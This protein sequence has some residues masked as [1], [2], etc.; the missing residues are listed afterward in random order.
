MSRQAIT[1][2]Y[3]TAITSRPQTRE[4]L[5]EITNSN[6]MVERFNQVYG[7]WFPFG[8]S[9]A[10]GKGKV[11]WGWA[12]TWPHSPGMSTQRVDNFIKLVQKMKYPSPGKIANNSEQVIGQSRGRGFSTIL[13]HSLDVPALRK[14]EEYLNI[15]NMLFQELLEK[16][17][18][19]NAEIYGPDKFPDISKIKD[20]AGPGMRAKGFMPFVLKMAEDTLKAKFKM[21]TI[22]LKRSDRAR[23]DA[24]DARFVLNS[25]LT[26]FIFLYFA[27]IQNIMPIKDILRYGSVLDLLQAMNSAQSNRSKTSTKG[28]N[29]KEEIPGKVFESDDLLIVEPPSWQFSH[30]YF[31]EV[32]RS[33]YTPGKIIRGANW[34][35]SSSDQS[36]FDRYTNVNQNHLYYFLRRTKEEEI[37]ALRTC[38]AVRNFTSDMF[39][40]AQTDPFDIITAGIT[41]YEKLRDEYTHT[42]YNSRLQASPDSNRLYEMLMDGYIAAKFRYDDESIDVGEENNR[43]ALKLF[44]EAFKA[45]KLAKE[46]TPK[47][48]CNLF[49]FE[50][51]NQANG[52]MPYDSF[53]SYFFGEGDYRFF[54]Q[55][56]KFCSIFD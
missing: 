25:S 40:I 12:W 55:H 36:H 31:G 50:L 7:P 35:T 9:P 45:I 32:R 34:C 15:Y 44:Y 2:I 22:E 17:Y 16:A 26:N 49:T 27:K 6:K 3:E 41:L 51:R 48:Y 24:Y 1:S 10:E 20:P 30:R 18:K 19:I 46:H 23:W 52:S 14:A 21:W 37:G 4:L 11:D 43:I 29:I 33:L 47:N 8:S 28:A 53:K 42:T 56:L 5:N 13:V 54:I 38:G 39:N